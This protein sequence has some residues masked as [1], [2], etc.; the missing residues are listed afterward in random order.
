MFFKKSNNATETQLQK[1]AQELK[2]GSVEAFRILYGKYN[3]KVY[4]FCLRMLGDEAEAK[5][6]FQETFIKIYE[7][8]FEFQGLNFSS[9]LFTIARRICLNT[10]RS[11]KNYGILDDEYLE[12]QKENQSDFGAQAY[13]SRAIASLPVA[14]REALILREYEECSYQEIAGILG[15]ELSLAKIRVHRARILLRNILK[16]LQKELYES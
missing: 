7:H 14:L 15:I 6:A 12:P 3:Q 5:D 13:I 2:G 10:I 8:R 1:A 9:W 16:P 11:R 4:R